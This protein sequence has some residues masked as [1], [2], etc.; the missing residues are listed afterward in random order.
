MDLTRE[1][2]SIASFW[3]CLKLLMAPMI[4]K[5]CEY[6]GIKGNPLKRI[7][8]FL[9]QRAQW[10]ILKGETSKSCRVTS[11]VRQGMIMGLLLFLI[12]ISD[13]T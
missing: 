2:T 12:Y 7:K 13:L 11:G 4:A 9:H 3:T 1:N 8:S 10:V 5:T 6:Y